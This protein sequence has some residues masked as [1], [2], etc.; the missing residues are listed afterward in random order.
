M[1]TFFRATLAVACLLAISVALL[2]A[3][4]LTVQVSRTK[5][6]KEAKFW[7]SSVATLQAGDA[8]EEVSR[9]GDW[10]K[11]RTASGTEGWVHGSAVTSRSIHLTGGSK[12]AERGASAD[13]ISL[14]GKGFTEEVEDQYKQN[15]SGLAFDGVDWMSRIEVKEGEL[16]RFL[17]EGKLAEWGGGS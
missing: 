8:V 17:Q 14:A 3:T 11:V 6:R 4:R 7:A 10:V 1:R 2:A 13:E 9:T 12:T 15:K 16:K 5:M